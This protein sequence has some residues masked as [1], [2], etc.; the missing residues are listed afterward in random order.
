MTAEQI[1]DLGLFLVNIFILWLLSKRIDLANKRMDSHFDSLVGLQN[2]VLELSKNLNGLTESHVHI[3]EFVG[4]QLQRE[5]ARS[6]KRIDEL[7]EKL[8]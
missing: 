3:Q 7:K 4:E 5:L 1:T 2:G 6:Q 8:Q